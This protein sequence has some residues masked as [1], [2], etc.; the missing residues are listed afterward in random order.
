MP[1]LQLGFASP[2]P[3]TSGIVLLE[4]TGRR[5]GAKRRVPLAC[6]DYGAFLTV[7]TVRN[8]SQ[9]IRNLAAEP[10]A[11]VWLRGRQRTVLSAVFQQGE[12]SDDSALPED[13]S[14]LAA[15]AFTR[16]SGMSLAI[17]HLQ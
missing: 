15:R 4:V 16:F 9:W 14:T 13:P 1:A 12:R 2:L 17:L 8:E 6:T 5:S 10:R 7:S 3:L 11:T